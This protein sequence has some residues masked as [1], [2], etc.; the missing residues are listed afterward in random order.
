MSTHERRTS[1]RENVIALRD[2]AIEVNK[3]SSM[4]I[5]MF[6]AISTQKQ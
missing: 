1:F 4:L 5:I 6:V 3:L 2:I